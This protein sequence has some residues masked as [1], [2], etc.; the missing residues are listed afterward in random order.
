[1][2]RPTNFENDREDILIVTG[3]VLAARYSVTRRP[4]KYDRPLYVVLTIENENGVTER[5]N[6]APGS[7]NLLVKDL[8][9]FVG[10]TLLF[11]HR[12]WDVLWTIDRDS[13]YKAV[14]GL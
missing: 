12:A 4:G 11:R 3:A 14:R 5:V 2:F 9:A 6:V 1:M 7:A 10:L 13:F 8:D